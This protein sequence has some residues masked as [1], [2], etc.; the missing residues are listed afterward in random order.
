MATEKRLIDANELITD[1][2]GTA[3]EVA[4]NAPYHAEWFTRMHDRQ[5]EIIE[6]INGQRTVDAVEVVRC[7]DCKYSYD[8]EINRNYRC[9]RHARDGY[10]QVFDATFTDNDF[11]SYG[12][13]RTNV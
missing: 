6:I 10:S 8:H 9:H 5:C 1:I 3:S 11:C 2:Q 12:E 7:K 13:R 4:M